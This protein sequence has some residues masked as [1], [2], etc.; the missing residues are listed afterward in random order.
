MPP[1]FRCR[2]V[3]PLVCLILYGLFSYPTKWNLKAI[4][5]DMD[6]ESKPPIHQR[7]GTRNSS[8]DPSTP[9]KAT[10]LDNRSAAQ[11]ALELG[12]WNLMKPVAAERWEAVD[13]LTCVVRDDT[14]QQE[15]KHRVPSVILLGAQKGGT[16]ALSGYLHKHPS[17]V[18]IKKELHFFSEVLDQDAGLIQNGSGMDSKHILDYYQDKF[19]GKL[20]PLKRIKEDKSLHI[21]DATPIYLLASDRVFDRILC[22]CPWVKFLV[23]LRNPIDRAWSQYHMQLGRTLRNRGAFTTFEEYIQLDMDVLEEVGMT[24]PNATNQVEWEAATGSPHELDAAWKQYTRLGIN[25]PIGRGLYS[26]QIR[27]LLQ[28]MKQYNKSRDDL[29]VLPSEDLRASPDA[30]YQRILKFLDFQPH[31]LDSYKLIHST[32]YRSQVM[33]PKTR[34]RLELLFAPYNRQLAALLGD[35]WQG[36]WD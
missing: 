21:L 15:W 13:N 18:H 30:T 35:E 27:H 23:L 36:I 29:M 26:V 20:I 3:L 28:V 4:Q 1:T 9:P 33:N 14:I 25:S 17:V 12:F 24:L 2:Y 8:N 10:K 31:S 7:T 6:F 11:K 32:T 19:I 22:T 16:S 5:A 34:E